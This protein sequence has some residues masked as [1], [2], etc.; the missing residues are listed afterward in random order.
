MK[1]PFLISIAFVSWCRAFVPTQFPSA[2]PRLGS[3]TTSVLSTAVGKEIDLTEKDATS[4][5]GDGKKIR[6]AHQ[7]WWP[8]SS[9]FYLDKERPNP[10]DLLN[11]KLVVFWSESEK[12]WKC[13]DDRCSHRFAPL[14]EGRVLKNGCLQCAYHGWEFDGQGK[15]VKVPQSK[16]GTGGR[17][18][19]GY[20]IRVQASMIFVR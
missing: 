16:T 11:K 7:N 3:S 6:P 12:E 5:S 9:T 20:P 4:L 17:N 19:P 2:Y 18:V 13:L 15:N 14:S 1:V 10:V 8:V